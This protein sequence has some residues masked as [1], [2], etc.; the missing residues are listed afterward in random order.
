MIYLS[1]CHQAP[2][3]PFTKYMATDPLVLI[4]PSP[5]F[6]IGVAMAPSTHDELSS[7]NHSQSLEEREQ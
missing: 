1:P 2:T 5:T 3:I 4:C 6:I 7:P